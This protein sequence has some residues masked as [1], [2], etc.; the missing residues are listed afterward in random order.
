MGQD[1]RLDRAEDA[2]SRAMRRRARAAMALP[3]LCCAALLV[4]CEAPEPA[5]SSSVPPSSGN[6]LVAMASKKKRR[7]PTLH[8]LGEKG[9]RVKV[10]VLPGDASV[11]IDGFAAR[12]RNGVV[13]ITGRVGEVHRL[14]IFK[15]TE[16]LERD[17]TIGEASASPALV[18]LAVR[19]MKPG[20]DDGRTGAPVKRVDPLF[21]EEFK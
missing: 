14:R 19:P 21:A 17:V 3:M 13:E 1:R 20:G 9:R 18:D 8:D 15:G 11:E 10:V 2:A 12:R 6:D 16:Q 5:P 7:Q 4:A